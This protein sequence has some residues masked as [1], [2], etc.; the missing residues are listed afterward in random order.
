MFYYLLLSR[1]K[2]LSFGL[3]FLELWSGQF[4]LDTF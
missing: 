4:G 3:H 2:S 1:Q